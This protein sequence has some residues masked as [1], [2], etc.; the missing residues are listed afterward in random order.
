MKRVISPLQ[1]AF[2]QDCSIHDN[3]LQ[4][5]EILNVFHKSTN[6]IDWCALKL[7][8]KKAYERIE[9]DFLW[10]ILQSFGFSPLW[11]SWVKEYVTNVSYSIKVNGHT[12]DWFKSSRGMWQGD[13]LSP[14][15]FI[16]CME[17]FIRQLS[18]AA[19]NPKS[20]LG[21]KIHPKTMNIPAL[22]FADDSL[23]FCKASATAYSSL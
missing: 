2:T 14:Y 17:V 7:D 1:N 18:I 10:A 11:I 13:P 16:I 20:G 22:L 3:I 19:F 8:M 12:S 6:K 15:L 9:W 5:Q 4:V 23:L 21:F